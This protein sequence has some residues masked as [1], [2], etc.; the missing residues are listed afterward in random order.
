[1]DDPYDLERFVV[2]QNQAGDFDAATEE[3]RAG[4]KRTHWIWFV[5][6]QMRGL[7]ASGFATRYGIGS[8]GEAAAYLQH[9]VLGPRLQ[10]CTKLVLRSPV[11]DATMLMGSS[12]DALKL[13]SS[14]TLFAHVADDD[15]G[16]VAVLR[17]YFHGGRD[18]KTL[19]LLKDTDAKAQ[20]EVEEPPLTNERGFW[21]RLRWL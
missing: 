5:F 4:R 11:V 19:D 2:A 16:F 17:K 7:G 21:S 15:E 12:V 20:S 1:M 14:M 10:Q 3:L 6:P 18:L 8:G 13:K 9:D